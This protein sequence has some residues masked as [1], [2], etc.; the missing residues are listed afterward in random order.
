MTGARI[1]AGVADVNTPPGVLQLMADIGAELA[2]RGWTL[3]HAGGPADDSFT[4]GAEM[5]GGA[6]E[7]FLPAPGHH[8]HSGALL[9]RPSDRALAGISHF[10]SV[11]DAERAP[12]ACMAHVLLGADLT[13]PVRYLVCWSPMAR[14]QGHCR[15]AIL[16]ATKKNIEILNLAYMPSRMRAMKMLGRPESPIGT[17]HPA[18]VGRNIDE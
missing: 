11:T 12:A 2:K 9:D 8:G 16:L 3:R 7:L 4:Q 10:M 5:A 13:V 14:A 6:A 15:P 1:Y 17:D 18:Q